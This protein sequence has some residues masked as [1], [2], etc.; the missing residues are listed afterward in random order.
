MG[1]EVCDVRVFREI[2]LDSG[3]TVFGR[4][5]VWRMK[6]NSGEGFFFRSEDSFKLAIVDS[7]FVFCD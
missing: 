2:L 6:E 1:V 5:G 4:G 3:G 7:L